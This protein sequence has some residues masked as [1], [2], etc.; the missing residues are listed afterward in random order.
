MA[1]GRLDGFWELNL[2]EV[3]IAAGMLIVREAGGI[4]TDFDG[5]TSDLPRRVAAANAKV[6]GKMLAAL[7]QDKR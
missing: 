7:N 4:V 3:D 5:G 1:C 2:K 6:H